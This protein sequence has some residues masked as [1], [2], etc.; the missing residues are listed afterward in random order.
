MMFVRFWV[1]ASN[2][3]HELAAAARTAGHRRVHDAAAA[4]FF[5]VES[6]GLV[7]TT[8]E[9]VEAGVPG[10]VIGGRAPRY[11]FQLLSMPGHR[12]GIGRFSSAIQMVDGNGRVTSMGYGDGLDAVLDSFTGF[13][14][15][16]G[17]ASVA[18]VFGTDDPAIP[19]A[20]EEFLTL[21]TIV[22]D[23][24]PLDDDTRRVADALVAMVSEVVKTGDPPRGVLRSTLS[25]FAAKLDRFTDEFAGAAG[26]ALGVTVGVGTGAAVAGRLPQLSA[27]IDKALDVLR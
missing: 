1:D 25:W 21:W 22:V 23:D 11:E 7:D 17:E 10:D 26:K 15:H 5:V 2:G 3:E 6:G 13:L 8:G 18:D 12:P 4:E 24:L 16:V 9:L 19:A 14:L 27:A 20:V